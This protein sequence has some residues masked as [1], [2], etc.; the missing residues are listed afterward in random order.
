MDLPDVGRVI[1]WFTSDAANDPDLIPA[2]IAQGEIT[3]WKFSHW[4]EWLQGAI[5]ATIR[6]QQ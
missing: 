2:R 1:V 3:S 6:H 5:E 4:G